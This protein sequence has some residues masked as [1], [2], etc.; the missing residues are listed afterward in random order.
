MTFSQLRAFALVARLGSMRAAAAALGIS[1]PAV[2]SAIAALRQDLGDP[3]VVRS[4]GGIALTSGGRRL[5]A[6]ADEIV[7]LADRARREVAG[8]GGDPD[9]LRVA[10]TASFEEHGAGALFDSFTAR[11]PGTQVEVHRAAPERL[12]ALLLERSTDI[13]LGACPSTSGHVALDVVPFLRYQRIVIAAEGHALA[14]SPHVPLSVLRHE[15]WLAG[16]GGTEQPSQES[17]WWRESGLVPQLQCSPSEE[18]ALE[19]VRSGRA[20]TLALR[21]VVRRDLRAGT[22]VQLPVR[23][24]PVKGLWCASVLGQ[25]KCAPSARALQ[26]FCTTPDAMAAMV[27][28]AG[29]PRPSRAQTVHVNLWS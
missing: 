23:G 17:R 9:V 20:L 13:A 25:G 15:R 10:V 22:L 18:E 14:T 19:E 29:I 26:R 11:S 16:P 24:T 21:H 27:G 5:A 8:A 6:H 28:T 3:L 4:G 2:S 1:E 12:A 7:G